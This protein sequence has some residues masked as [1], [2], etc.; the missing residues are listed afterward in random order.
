[1]TN[2]TI[3]LV[4]EGYGEE[5]AF[6]NLMNRL[7]H[8]HFQ[9]YDLFT[10]T[11]KNAKGRHQLTQIG[12]FEKYIYHCIRID[13][14]D[15]ILILL[16][17][18]DDCPIDLAQDFYMRVQQMNIHVPIA[19]VCAKCE[20]EAWFLANIDALIQNGLLK[21]DVTYHTSKIEE[22]RDVKGWLSSNMP[23][24]KYKEVTDQ[25]KMTRYIE[26][27]RTSDLSRSFRRLTHAVHELID[28]IDQQKIVIS[29]SF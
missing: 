3:S 11:P 7:L 24:G 25:L 4:V 1:M 20:Y 29:P 8:N 15:G 27:E 18:D 26:F 16:D 6:P 23:S 21:S 5:N 12:G 13:K 14:A 2:K 9:R 28:A 10:N 19:L 17:A 22:K